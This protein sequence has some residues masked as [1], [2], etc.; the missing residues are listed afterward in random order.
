LRGGQYHIH[1][2]LCFFNRCD[3]ESAAS[4]DLLSMNMNWLGTP[5]VDL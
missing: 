3:S 4:T 1:Q 2:L 5:T